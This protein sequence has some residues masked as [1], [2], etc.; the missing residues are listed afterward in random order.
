MML[1]R[2]EIVDRAVILILKMIHVQ[3]ADLKEELTEL[4]TELGVKETEVF[5]GLLQINSKMWGLEADLRKGKEG[6]LGL[7]E[8]GRRAI[9][10]RDL[11]KQRVTL[12]NSISK[13][14]DIKINHASS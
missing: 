11:N 8:V 9:A 14:K 6:E 13:F 2:G 10:I 12:K 1:Q 4:L 7:E 3:D 5:I